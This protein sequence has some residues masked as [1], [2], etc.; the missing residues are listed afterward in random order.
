M[1]HITL[2]SLLAARESARD[3]GVAPGIAPAAAA[4]GRTFDE[5]LALL[6]ATPCDPPGIA[7]AGLDEGSGWPCWA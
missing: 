7:E 5:A 1:D 4:A 6:L 3:A 2:S